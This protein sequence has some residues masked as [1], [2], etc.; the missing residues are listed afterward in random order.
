MTQDPFYE[1]QAPTNYQVPPPPAPEKKNKTL[2]IILVVAAVLLL[3]C[4][5]GVSGYL[6]WTY[7][8]AILYELGLSSLMTLI[9]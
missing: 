2:I 9:N 7:G 4:C 8:D 3:C 1:P 5:V 6:L